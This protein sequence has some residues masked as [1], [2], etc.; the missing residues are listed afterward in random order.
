MV[1]EWLRS[2]LASWLGW[3]PDA[4]RRLLPDDSAG[5]PTIG[6]DE[7]TPACWGP[8]HG[9]SDSFSTEPAV[10][11]GSSSPARSAMRTPPLANHFAGLSSTRPLPFTT[12][13]R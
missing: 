7:N 10:E 3:S 12:L 5:T 4:Q 2:W 6:R 8:F 1:K 13:P 9:R 11:L